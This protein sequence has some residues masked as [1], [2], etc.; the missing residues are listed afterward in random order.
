MSI[1]FAK[2]IGAIYEE[3]VEVV[4]LEVFELQKN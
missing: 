1:S 4:K 3:N 2:A